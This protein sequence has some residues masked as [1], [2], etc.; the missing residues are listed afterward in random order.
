MFYR[1]DNKFNEM[2]MNTGKSGILLSLSDLREH[3]HDKTK[4]YIVRNSLSFSL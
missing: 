3:L 4:L 1:K 2:N